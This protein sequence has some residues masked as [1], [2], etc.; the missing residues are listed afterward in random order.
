MPITPINSDLIIS[1]LLRRA[2]TMPDPSAWLNARHGEAMDAV[3]AGDEYVTATSDEGGSSTAERA[4]PAS[5]LLQ[6]YEAALQIYEAESGAASGTVR[7][8]DFSSQP[9]TLG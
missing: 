2:R 3:L 1:G 8:G 5:L 7:Y 9:C 6:F 4:V